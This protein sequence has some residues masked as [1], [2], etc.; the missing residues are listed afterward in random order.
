MISQELLDEIICF[1][2]KNEFLSRELI[3]KIVIYI[4]NN[5]DEITKNHFKGLEFAKEEWDFAVAGCYDDGRI[6]ADY[7]ALIEDYDNPEK[8]FLQNNLAI[9]QC[10]MH[11]IGH[12]KHKSHKTLDTFESKLLKYSGTSYISSLYFNRAFIKT[13]D[14]KLS[15]RIA[16]KKTKNFYE[17]NIAIIPTERIAEIG[18]RKEL[19]DSLKNYPNFD[20]KYFNEYRYVNNAYIR[21]LKDGYKRVGNGKYSVPIIEYFTKLD[22]LCDLEKLGFNFA[23]RTLQKETVEFNAETKMLYGFPIKP[24]DIIEINKLKIKS[25]R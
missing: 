8:S 19:L 17:N 2:M 9:I 6:T 23:K 21:S 22:K 10:L 1:S 5:S 14:M 13:G 25:R 3:E 18:S 4:V 20:N 7:D 24:I 15:G 16:L 12:L 11:E